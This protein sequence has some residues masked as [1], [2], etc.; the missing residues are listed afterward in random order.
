M[1]PLKFIYSEKATCQKSPTLDLT[2]SINYKIQIGD[3]KEIFYGLL[4][5]Y[6]I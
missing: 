5:I 1:F 2:K 3:L 6:K 4:K